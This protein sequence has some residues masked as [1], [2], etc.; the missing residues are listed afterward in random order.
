MTSCI[1]ALRCPNYRMANAIRWGGAVKIS[2]RSF[3][4]NRVGSTR[5]FFFCGAAEKLSVP[6][7]ERLNRGDSLGGYCGGRI[8]KFFS[9]PEIL[10]VQTRPENS[11]AQTF[12]RSD[13]KL[14]SQIGHLF[15]QARGGGQKSGAFRDGTGGPAT[16]I[17]PRVSG[18][19]FLRAW[20]CVRARNCGHDMA[21]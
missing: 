6:I 20:R 15:P 13:A 18:N 17:F 14:R 5:R 10:G 19:F 21:I 11:K 2:T 16:R 8:R 9:R 4:R 7:V 12:Q 3:T 1:L